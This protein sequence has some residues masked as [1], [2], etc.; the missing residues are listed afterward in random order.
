MTYFSTHDIEYIPSPIPS[1]SSHF[2]SPIFLNTHKI[3]LIFYHVCWGSLRITFCS[4]RK[5]NFYLLISK[6]F[7]KLMSRREILC[8]WNL[9]KRAIYRKNPAQKK[10]FCRAIFVYKYHIEIL[11]TIFNT[12]LIALFFIL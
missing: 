12:L 8:I 7:E 9:Q 2:F 10:Y 1:S 3:C 5:G 11:I 4:R 6:D